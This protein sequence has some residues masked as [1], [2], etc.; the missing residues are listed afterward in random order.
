MNAAWLSSPVVLTGMRMPSC[1]KKI[2]AECAYYKQRWH[3]W[4]VPLL[5]SSSQ[6]TKHSSRYEA[7]HVFAIP[8]V[9]FFICAIGLFILSHIVS[10][11]DSATINSIRT[12]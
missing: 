11:L 10:I 7:D 3:F 9:L 8:T 6:S 2:P 5:S 12:F 1:A 4:S